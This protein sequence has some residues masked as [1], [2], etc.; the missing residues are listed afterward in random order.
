MHGAARFHWCM[1]RGE[2]FVVEKKERT[3]R[4]K[5]TSEHLEQFVVDGY[6][7][8]KNVKHVVQ[9][10]VYSFKS[11]YCRNTIRCL[12]IHYFM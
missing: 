2:S 9:N 8:V 10:K 7:G 6:E 5:R 3:N 1:G 12:N 4:R 11:D